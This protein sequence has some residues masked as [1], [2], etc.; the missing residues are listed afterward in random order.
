[1][2]ITPR[3]DLET[4]FVLDGAGRI[5]S[6]REPLPSPLPRFTLVRGRASCAFAVRADVPAPLADEL[7]RLAR[8]EPS[9]DDLR[10]D[11][12]SGEPL[13]AERYLALAGGRVRS[14]PSFTFP[15]DLAAPV[16][17]MVV[18]DEQLLAHRFRGWV[19]GEIAAG[20]AP[21][22]AIADDGTPVSACFSARS[23]PLAAAAGVETAPD[24]R[25]RGLAPRVV[26]AWA[27]AIRA[28]GRTP[29]YGTDWTNSSSL[30]VAR[31][32]EL[33]PFAAH[34]SLFD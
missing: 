11:E 28:Q 32:L 14:G 34:W 3:L 10:L 20:R 2:T 21:V 25:G 17:V 7:G 19:A 33:E 1:M 12:L 26:A 31:K 30:A 22:M 16:D 8:E 4:G 13:H 15:G 18:E 23:S 6:T 5:A 27:L 24:H 9:L 29:L